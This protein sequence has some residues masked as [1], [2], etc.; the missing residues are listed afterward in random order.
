[1]GG[2]KDSWK[3]LQRTAGAEQA[4][5]GVK[6]ALYTMGSKP[7]KKTYMYND[8]GNQKLPVSS[9]IIRSTRNDI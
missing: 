6:L 5:N 7:W 4:R 8:G 3:V 1:M 2:Q 9:I